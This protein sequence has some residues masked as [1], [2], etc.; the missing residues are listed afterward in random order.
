MRVNKF[1]ISTAVA[2]ASIAV[3]STPASALTNLLGNPGFQ[4]PLV[5]GAVLETPGANLGACGKAAP[6]AGDD[7]HCWRVGGLGTYVVHNDFKIGAKAVK[8][9]AGTQMVWLS[10]GTVL[11]PN[12]FPRYFPG[13]VHQTVKVTPGT[14]HPLQLSYATM[15]FSPMGTSALHVRVYACTADANACVTA[16]DTVLSSNSTGNPQNMGWKTFSTIIPVNVDMSLIVVDLSNNL[17]TIA[18]SSGDVAIDKFVLN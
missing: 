16:T 8:P 5:S 11:D 13:E 18:M 17:P 2:L 6:Y 9:A 1:F 12:G 14:N 7:V 10:G 15:P 3:L 4:T